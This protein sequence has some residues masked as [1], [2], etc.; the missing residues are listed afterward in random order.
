MYKEG[1]GEPRFPDKGR[2]RESNPRP[3]VPKT[4]IIPLDQSDN[5]PLIHLFHEVMKS[6]EKSFIRRGSGNLG[7]L[8]KVQPRFELRLQE[9]KPCVITN[10]TIRPKKSVVQ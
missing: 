10:Y 4:R 9:S 5:P 7:S 2:L 3:L 8:R 1:F 6:V